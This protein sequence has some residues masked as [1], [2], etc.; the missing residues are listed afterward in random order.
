M[1]P[2]EDMENMR[3]ELSRAFSS[4]GKGSTFNYFQ[5]AIDMID[6]G[7]EI[8][9]VVDLPGVRKEDISI[10]CTENYLEINAKTSDKTEEKNEGYYYSERSDASFQRGISLPV[11][12]IP[13][14]AKSSF[15]N[16]VLEVRLPKREK[17]E[18]RKGHKIDVE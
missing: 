5:P 12:V 3:R 4:Y 17:T 9:I 1:S 10:N 6:K 7:D 16:G 13:E 18:V 14:E 11:R 15:K 2:W 8:L